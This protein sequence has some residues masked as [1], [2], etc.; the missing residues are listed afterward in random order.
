MALIGTLKRN[1]MKRLYIVLVVLSM[2]AVSVYAQ[3]EGGQIKYTKTAS[4]I[5]KQKSGQ[6]GLDLEDISNNRTEVRALLL[7]IFYS[8]FCFTLRAP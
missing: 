2:L 4:M 7:A 6:K 8:Y 1:K 3:A 5:D